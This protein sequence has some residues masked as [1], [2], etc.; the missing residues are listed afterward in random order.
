MAFL[1]FLERLLYFSGLV[2]AGILLVRLAG[3]GL[4]A[5]YRFFAL[6]LFC[7]LVEGVVVLIVPRGTNA[8][9]FT[10]IAMESVLW[11]VQVLV[12][13]ELLSLVVRKYPGIARS[14]RIFLWFALAAAIAVSFVLGFVH[15]SSGPAG[16]N[17][18]LENYLLIGR[19]IAFTLLLF[20]VLTLGFLF[21][22]PIPLSRNVIVYAIGFSVYFTCR[23]LTRLAG[24]LLGPQE[25][26]VLSTIS[27]SILMCCLL[28]W[29]FFL[30]KRG[31]ATSMTV[32]HRWEPG[33]SRALV[34]QLES[35]NQTL[36]RTS[37]K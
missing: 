12:V 16:Q 8:Y 6:L 14:G 26:M 4:L 10:Y 2:V 36:L 13:V 11:L 28:F 24:T 17:F 5:R 23:A 25:F 32:G 1:S 37:Q 22:F 20:L 7:L 33:E 27:L 31:E 19:A 3:E 29:T 15:P 35:I 30:N 18:L 9:F 21:W 34:L